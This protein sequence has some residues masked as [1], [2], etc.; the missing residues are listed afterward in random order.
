[1]TP[2]AY[3]YLGNYCRSSDD[4]VDSLIYKIFNLDN[5]GGVSY[6]EIQMMLINLP[7]LGFSC[8]TNLDI[9]DLFYE[10]IKTQ[11]I[12]C[13]ELQKNNTKEMELAIQ[14]IL[15]VNTAHHD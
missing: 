13:L 3:L 5:R 2:Y 7:D 8:T 10:H 14:K 1:M 6:E 9:P 15:E 12:Q 4:E 11:L